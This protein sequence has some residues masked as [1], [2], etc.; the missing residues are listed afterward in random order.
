MN[1]C[2]D[3]KIDPPVVEYDAH[4]ILVFNG[5]AAIIGCAVYRAGHGPTVEVP[6]H[7]FCDNRGRSVYVRRE[8][9]QE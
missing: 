4:L 2:S 7:H 9:P 8:L 6:A 5:T 3:P 1:L